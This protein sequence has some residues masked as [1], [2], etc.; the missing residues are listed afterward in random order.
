MP[1][2]DPSS[3]AKLDPFIDQL[4]DALAAEV[5]QEGDEL[6]YAGKLTYVI[7]R[8]SLLVIE[9]IFGTKLKY[10]NI[11]LLLGI[12]ESVKLEF[13]ERLGAEA[14]RDKRR[15]NGDVDVIENFQDE[16]ERVY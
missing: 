10:M 12:M 4:A 1:Y 14:E 9:K 11:A 6:K 3:R 5:V 8:L 16:L 2:I 13:Y 7:M 15:L